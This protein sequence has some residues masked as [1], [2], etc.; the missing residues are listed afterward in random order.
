MKSEELDNLIR[1]SLSRGPL[2][3][4]QLVSR[5]GVNRTSIRRVILSKPD[6]Y[7]KDGIRQEN[8]KRFPSPAW[9]LASR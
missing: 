4:S 8:R 3:L 7:E 5:I 1:K 9:K 2:T 6:V